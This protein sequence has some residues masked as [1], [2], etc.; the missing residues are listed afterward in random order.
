MSRRIIASLLTIAAGAASAQVGAT[1]EAPPASRRQAAR[2]KKAAPPPAAQPATGIPASWQDLRYPPLGKIEIP[3]VETTVLPNGMK[4]YLLESRELPTISGIALVRTGNLFDPADKVGLATVTG[5]TLRSGGTKAL[6]GDQI[7]EQLEDLAASVEASI[8]ESSGSVSF[9][10]LTPDIDKVLRLFHDVLTQPEFRAD[11]LELAKTQLRGSISRRNDEPDSIASREFA[12]IVYGRDNSYGWPMEYAHVN[13][14]SRDDLIGFYQRSFFP[15]NVMLAVYG[16]FKASEMKAKIEAL[17][18]DWTVK[19]PPASP[20]PKV[21]AKATPGVHLAEKDNINQT[22]FQIGH[23]GGRLN[24]EDYPALDV[25]ADILGGGFKSR[26]FA[27]I[28][29]KLGLAYSIGADWA[30]EFDHPGVFRISGSTKSSSATETIEAIRKEIERIRS[31]EVTDDELRS[32]KETAINSFVFN[33]DTR[34]KTIGRLLNYEYFGYSKDFLFEYQKKIAAV[35]KADILRV[36]KKHIRPAD[37]SYVV[38]ADPKEFV[39]P[40]ASLGLPVHMINL[41]IPEPSAATA[42]ADPG[43]HEKGVA[44]MRRMQQAV[45]GVAKLEAIKDLQ[46]TATVQLD[47]SAGGMRA[48][49]K[50]LWLKP[51][52]FRQELDLPF[53]RVVTY[54]DGTQG[55]IKTPQGEGALA[56]PALQ[57]AKGAI[58]RSWI[59]LMLS[60]RDPDRTISAVS[61]STLQITNKEGRSTMLT[62]DPVSGLPIRQSYLEG[63]AT[64]EEVWSDFREVNGVKFAFKVEVFQASKKYLDGVVT[65]LKTNTGI[66]EQDVKKRQ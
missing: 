53:G 44:I 47:A 16:D 20:F 62:I 23:L 32:A 21:V 38:V 2:A 36:A 64:V 54:T 50:N 31:A 61:D 58:F 22:F 12:A 63:P 10:A 34:A 30:A 57:Q 60:D 33:F 42:K 49:Q 4:L 46:Q 37:F 17:F 29:S 66:T 15:S 56:G 45:G 3:T 9:A 19:Q 6:T 55:W 59:T 14:I 7:D 27:E 18:A 41:A 13:R 35:T 5:M 65:E 51:N 39:K 25:L 8:G 1:P 26:L 48:T 28:R 11:K 40:L 52:L 43:A 24:D